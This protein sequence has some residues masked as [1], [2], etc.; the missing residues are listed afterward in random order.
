MKKFFIV[1]VA[2]L[3]P[4]TLLSCSESNVENN[5]NTEQSTNKKLTFKSLTELYEKEGLKQNEK[6]D[7]IKGYD[8]NLLSDSKEYSEETNRAGV[9]AKDNKVVRSFI[10]CSD[11]KGNENRTKGLVEVLFANI[12]PEFRDYDKW[13]SDMFATCKNNS[14]KEYRWKKN[15]ML[16]ITRYTKYSTFGNKFQ[17]DIMEDKHYGSLIKESEDSTNVIMLDSDGKVPKED[18]KEESLLS[19][20]FSKD[21]TLFDTIFAKIVGL[22]KTATIAYLQGIKAG[23]TI[24]GNGIIVSDPAGSKNKVVIIFKDDDSL[25]MMTCFNGDRTVALFYTDANPTFMLPDKTTVR[26]IEAAK[27][28][29][30]E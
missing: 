16:I 30:F 3:I 18:K 1:L 27:K 25:S 24:D 9:F 23:A 11:E 21:T 17:I 15:D 29:L 12:I 10:E 8:R 19:A 7:K 14:S 6:T 20:N 13:L 4:L 28:S 26:S 2:C 22:D 5:T